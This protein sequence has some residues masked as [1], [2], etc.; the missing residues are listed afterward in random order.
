MDKD[1]MPQS[2]CSTSIWN[3]P[4]IMP[5][6]S[7]SYN[8]CAPDIILNTKSHNSCGPWIMLNKISHNSFVPELMLNTKSHHLCASGLTPNTLYNSN[9]A[10]SLLYIA[11]Q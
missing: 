4:T 11:S 10:F 2:L 9:H 3:A 6:T 1:L 8:S 5:N 7:N